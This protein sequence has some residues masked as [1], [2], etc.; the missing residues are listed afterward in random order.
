MRAKRS[1][2]NLDSKASF[3]AAFSA[4]IAFLRSDRSYST[5]TILATYN[6]NLI[7]KLG[8]IQFNRLSKFIQMLLPAMHSTIVSLISSAPL[9]IASSS[10]RGLTPIKLYPL[11]KTASL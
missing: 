8:P 5:M 10:A 3:C 11:A 6:I 7:D 4:L 9:L 2:N 1:S